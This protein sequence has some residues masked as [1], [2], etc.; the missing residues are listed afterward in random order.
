MIKLIK[1][2]E[3]EF[4]MLQL[5]TADYFSKVCTKIEYSDIEY[6]LQNAIAHNKETTKLL[7]QAFVKLVEGKIEVVQLIVKPDENDYPKGV[8]HGLLSVSKELKSII[9]EL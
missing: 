2:R 3:E 6:P 1:E 9:D 7:L 8:Y 4:E 5:K